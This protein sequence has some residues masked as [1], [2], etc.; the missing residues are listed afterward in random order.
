MPRFEVDAAEESTLTIGCPD[1]GTFEELPELPPRGTAVC[2]RCDADLEKRAGR[3]I[4]AA[5][6]CSTATFLLLFPSNILPL[7]RLHL[8]GMHGENVT[9]AGIRILF[10]RGWVFLPAIAAVM[11][12]ILPFF[13]FGLLSAVLGT[14]RLGRRPRWLAAAFR[15]AVWLDPWAML[16]VYLL[17]SCVGY[18]RL[19][20]VGQLHLTIQAGGW[21]FV[22]AALLTMLSRATLDQRTVWKAIGGE[23]ELDADTETL[24][25]TTCDVVQ[26]L[27]REGRPCVRCG[28]VLHV[29]KPEAIGRTVALLLAA[30]ILF[31]PA[32]IYPMNVSMQ[33]GE[34]QSYTIF[35]G[36]HELF[37][38]GLWPLGVVIF[39]TSILIPAGKIVAIGWCVVSV[40]RRSDRHVKQKTKVF[41][42]V[43]EL[44]RWSKTDPWVIV[45]FVP[46][47]N[48]G[49]LG[50]QDAGWGATAFVLMTLLTMFASLTFD[51]RLMWDA[52][53]AGGR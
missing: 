8:F 14:L 42:A 27:A 26:P 34:Q 51:P 15:W 20:K 21:C 6:A 53:A 49:V 32:N 29:R 37:S 35:T 52:A 50:S 36:V 33:L 24:S 9:M 10:E 22:A 38:A 30:F 48:F 43:A 23:P 13:R 39:C 17:A 25:C 2:I 41:R 12:V 16:D 31:F 45:F 47:M 7:I 3:S 5:L 1:C 44:G 28:A 46:L 11:V 40:W 19:T 18:Y 4:V